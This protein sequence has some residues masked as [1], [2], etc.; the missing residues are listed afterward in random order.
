[1]GDYNTSHAATPTKLV[2]NVDMPGL[3]PALL[4]FAELPEPVPLGVG[5][6][7]GELVLGPVPEAGGGEGAAVMTVNT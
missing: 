2:K 4:L 7:V 3:N 1:M 5:E 6:G